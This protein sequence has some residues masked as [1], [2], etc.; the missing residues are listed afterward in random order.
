L[1]FIADTMHLGLENDES[2][3]Q[4]SVDPVAEPM[5]EDAVSFEGILA[6]PL[7]QNA[8]LASIVLAL[9]VFVLRRRRMS[10]RVIE[11]SLA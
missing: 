6:L 11:K 5:V 2:E 3:S 9:L 1:Q 7:F 10:A 8:V 4:A